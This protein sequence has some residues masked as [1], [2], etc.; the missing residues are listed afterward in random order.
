[1]HIQIG[2]DG[3]GDSENNEEDI[4]HMVDWQPSIEFG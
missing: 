2:R 4:G 3:A 1:M